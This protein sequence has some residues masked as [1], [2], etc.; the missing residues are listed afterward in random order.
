MFYLN[1]LLCVLAIAFV[2]WM[3]WLVF[4][5]NRTI[6]CKGRDDYLGYAIVIIALVML[7]PI[8]EDE[9]YMVISA[10]RNTMLYLAFFSSLIPA[11]G[12]SEAGMVMALFTIPWSQITDLRVE[13]YMTNKLQVVFAAY[14]IK[15]K[16]LFSRA[17]TRQV[18]QALQR[19]TGEDVY[20]ARE[21]DPYL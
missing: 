16:L 1:I 9:E 14:G 12:I 11:R 13:A 2:F 7:F 19:C 21:L 10:M 18:I 6:V 3:A 8:S 5:R 20:M 4:R 17:R 15:H